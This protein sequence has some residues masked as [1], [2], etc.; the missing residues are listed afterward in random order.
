EMSNNIFRGI[1]MVNYPYTG[2]NITLNDNEFDGI[3][4]SVSSNLYA[5]VDIR[6]IETGSVELSNNVF[7]NYMNIG[8]LSMASKNVS[9]IENTFTPEATAE[10]F[11]SV[12]V[13]TKLMTNGVQ[14]NTNPNEIELIGNDF[15][16]GA[17][18][19]G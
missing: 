7:K 8:L 6:S 17:L 18:N 19:K 14:N 16:A 12:M 4:S 1:T 3:S 13:N 2:V 9:V 15:K 5:L 10:E 11:A